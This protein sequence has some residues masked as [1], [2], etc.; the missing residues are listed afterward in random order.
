MSQSCVCSQFLC[1]SKMW[2]DFIFPQKAATV[3]E[4]FVMAKSVRRFNGKL[5]KN[6][7]ELLAKFQDAVAN[8]RDDEVCVCVSRFRTFK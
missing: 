5:K 3:D 1:L 7:E 6:D 2:N 4:A 8:A